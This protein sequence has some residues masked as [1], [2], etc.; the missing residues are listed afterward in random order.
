MSLLEFQ[1]ILLSLNLPFT[2]QHLANIC[3]GTYT[4]I[5][6]GLQKHLSKDVNIYNVTIREPFFKCRNTSLVTYVVPGIRGT[7][8]GSEGVVV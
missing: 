3:F 6:G 4:I 8:S 1:S 5:E 7:E 2:Q